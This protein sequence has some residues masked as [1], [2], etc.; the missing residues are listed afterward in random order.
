MKTKR[1]N[2]QISITSQRLFKW[3]TDFYVPKD[4][5][6]KVRLAYDQYVKW[7]NI[8]FAERGGRDTLKRAKSIRLCF[9][10]WLA[11]DP[12]K[13]VPNVGLNAKGL[14]KLFTSLITLVEFRTTESA[15]AVL[16]ILTV[17][18]SIRLPPLFNPKPIEDTFSGSIPISWDTLKEPIL[19]G[20]KVNKG[21]CL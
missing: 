13:A 21:K 20:L 14:P 19:R 16:T 12:L 3:Y 9:T 5:R 18:R 4:L 15:R 11:G 10:R 17:T 2:I 7:L 6:P 8:Q 1:K